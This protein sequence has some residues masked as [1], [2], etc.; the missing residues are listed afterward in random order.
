MGVIGKQSV[1]ASIF[2]YIGFAFGALNS[3]VLFQNKNFFTLE[4]FGLTKVLVDVSLLIAM[5]CT[6]GTYPAIVKFYPFYT[7]YLPKKKNDFPFFTLVAVLLGCLLFLLLTPLFKEFII[8]KFGQRSPLFVQY[9]NLI[10]PLTISMTLLYLFEAYSWAVKKTVLPAIARELIVRLLT[11]VLILF[12][13]VGLLN[14]H[15]FINL[16]SLVYAPSVLFILIL[17]IKKGDLVFHISRS[18]VTK[19]LGGRII[20]FSLFLFSGQVLN[21]LARTLDSIIISSQSKGGLADTGL[22]TIATYFVALMEVPVRGMTGIAFATLAQAWKDNDRAKVFSIYKKTAL[23]LSI[24][25]LGMLSLLGLCIPDVIAFLGAQYQPMAEVVLILGVSKL[26][27]LGTGLNSHLLMTSKHWKIEFF[28]NILLVLFAGFFNYILV[29]NF[30]IVGSA[31][32]TLISF[33]VYN[34]TRFILIWYLFKMQPFG[35]NNLKLLGVAVIVFILTKLIYSFENIY[36]DIFFKSLV[37][38]LL[39][40]VILVK[41]KISEDFNALV[42]NMVG[43]FQNLR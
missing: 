24:A 43:R 16:F 10:Y 23:N 41:M 3:L 38:C 20:T 19:R 39:Y 13:M 33:T 8:R 21:I 36:F 31:W 29:R 27:D 22:F 17:L 35:T 1:R 15:Q 5:L 25:G 14:Y 7:S 42:K 9:F 37:F 34:L 4:Q 30:G 40:I 11:T 6:L 26:I 28:S 18:K 12:V 2:I 32:A